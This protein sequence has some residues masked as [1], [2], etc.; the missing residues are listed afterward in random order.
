VLVLARRGSQTDRAFPDPQGVLRNWYFPT[1]K[2]API[3]HSGL[4]KK[5]LV[6]ATRHDYPA[7]PHT[8]CLEDR[9]VL[10]LNQR[11]ERKTTRGREHHHRV[12]EP[13]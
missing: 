5:V 3:N 7:K 13:G 11:I 2:P 6:W 4:V 9:K 1:E 12:G 8:L 10:S